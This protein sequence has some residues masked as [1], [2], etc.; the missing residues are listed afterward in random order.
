MEFIQRMKKREFIEMGLKTL[1]ALLA[2]FV[3]IILM[4]GM[5]YSI[6][7]NSYMKNGGG[8]TLNGDSTTAYCIEVEDDQYFVL[9]H[10]VWADG[11]EGWGAASTSTELLSK[12]DCEALL[13]NNSVGELHYNAPNAFDFT[14]NWI[15]YLVITVFVAAVGGFFVYRFIAL[16]K[17][18]NKIVSNFEKTGEIEISNM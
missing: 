13:T 1:A 14:I 3:A 8:Y 12:S 9:Y 11:K 4:E 10:N 5:I 16:T 7:L 6:T 18:Y 17:E 2:C 15:H